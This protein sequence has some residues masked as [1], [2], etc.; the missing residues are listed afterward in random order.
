MTTLVD[1]LALMPTPTRSH[2]ETGVITPGYDDE[3]T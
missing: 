2:R 3:Q 1:L